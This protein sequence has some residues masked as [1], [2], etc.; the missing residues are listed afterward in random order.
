MAAGFFRNPVRVVFYSFSDVRQNYDNSCKSPVAESMCE[1]ATQAVEKNKKRAHHKGCTR[2]IC[3]DFVVGRKPVQTSTFS[4]LRIFCKSC[5]PGNF[6][7]VLLQ[8]F[9]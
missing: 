3:L 5:V 6:R 4:L 2:K 9:Q 1:A 8:I 7:I